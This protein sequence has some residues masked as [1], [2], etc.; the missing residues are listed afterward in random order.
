VKRPPPAPLPAGVLGLLGAGV[1]DTDTEVA[2]RAWS[3]GNA[4]EA[5]QRI[6]FAYV[7]GELCGVGRVPFTGDTE[8][9][10]FRCGAQAVGQALCA[11]V[12]ASVAYIPGRPATTEIEGD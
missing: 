7:S 8:G 10:A 2:L 3:R 6:A 11:L 1:P 9:T 12:G 5:Q 4:S